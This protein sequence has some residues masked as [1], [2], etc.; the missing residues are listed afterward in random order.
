MLALVI[1][2]LGAATGAAG[3]P[4]Q[5]PGVEQTYEGMVTCSFCRARH[6]A[7]LDKTAADCTLAC[8]RSGA[9]FAL[10]DGDKAYLLDGDAT[11]LKK[12][13]GQRA[14][15]AGFLTGNTI[16]VSSAGAGS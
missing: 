8:V 5:Q 6:S 13:V 11:L 7:K 3:A 1:A 12:V 2:T 9:Q 4:S 15:I 14:R 10:V 16:R